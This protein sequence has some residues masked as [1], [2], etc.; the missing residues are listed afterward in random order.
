VED[1]AAARHAVVVA[2]EVE[3]FE[4]RGIVDGTEIETVLGDFRP[5]LLILDVRLPNGPD[6]FEIARAT[7]R[8]TDIP[9]LFLTGADALEERLQGFEAGADDYLLKPF[10]MEELLARVRALLHRSRRLVSATLQ[11]RDLVVDHGNRQVQRAGTPVD[12][13][14][15]EY[16]LLRT[17]A[18][19]PGHVHSKQRL[20]TDV[21]G[22]DSF[23]PNLVEVHISALRRKLERHGPR[24]I[25]TERGR[26]YV[27]WP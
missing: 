13:T 20:M 8:A 25:H 12:L 5:D 22:F 14:G 18:G 27:I 2:L 21:W 26:G 9:L 15:V 4:V 10:A 1:D 7:R 16:E 6:G 23:D 3:G 17:L 19:R 24:M 11:V